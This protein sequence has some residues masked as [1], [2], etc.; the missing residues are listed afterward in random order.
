MI[1]TSGECRIS[2]FM[3]YNIAYAELYFTSTCF[4]DFDN[5]E[6]DKALIE[7]QNRNITK[8]GNNKVS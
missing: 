8:G 4:P 2:N 6:F 1:R 5:S 3:L 7:Y